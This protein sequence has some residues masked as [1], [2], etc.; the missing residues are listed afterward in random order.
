M[1]TPILQHKSPYEVRFNIKLDYNLLRTF[2]CLCYPYL[3]PYS[4]HKLSSRSEQCIFLGYSSIHIGYRCLSLSTNRLY[5]SW[6]VIFEESIYSYSHTFTPSLNKSIG[7]LGFSPSIPTNSPSIM[8]PHVQDPSTTV[9]R[10]EDPSITVASSTTDS[11][12]S[13]QAPLT[14]S[15]KT[16]DSEDNNITQS[17]SDLPSPSSTPPLKTKSLTEIYSQTQPDTH[18]P[19][20]ECLL[21]N[22]N[23]PCEPVSFSH[24]I[25]DSQWLKAMQTEFT[26]LQQNQTWDLVPRSSF[27]NVINGK[28]IFKLKYKSDGSIE[29]HKARLVAKGFK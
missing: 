22:I 14:S 12:S 26:T 13:D 20:P 4:S 29:C 9:P 15:P 2:G 28:W 7:I 17:S 25:N 11:N 23:T 10:T 19:V 1:T 18:H 8:I 6:N 3:R 5:I 16:T 24:A 21:T 27:M